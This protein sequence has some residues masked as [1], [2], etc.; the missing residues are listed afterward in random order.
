MNR[1]R[2]AGFT[3]I[4]MLVIAPVVIL[5]IG[6]FLT[7]TI[8]MTGEVISSRASNVLAYDVQEALNRIEQDV[9][10][11]TTFLAESN[12]TLVTSGDAQYQNGAA[13]GYNNDSTKWENIRTDGKKALI[14]NMIVTNGNP[15]DDGSGIV[16]L[17][18]QPNACDNPNVTKNKPMTMNVVYF[19]KDDALWR[20]TIMPSN[21]AV[22][23]DTCTTPWQ[24]PSCAPGYT[25]AFCK[26][27][28][29]KLLTGISE[30][31]FSIEYYATGAA[32][33]PNLTATTSS[34]V[35]T[36]K[37]ALSGMQT[38]SVA[39]SA[40]Q[41][42]A[43]R[44]V[45]RSGSLRTTRLDVNATTI[46]ATTTYATPSKPVV[47]ARVTPPDVAVFTWPDSSGGNVKYNVGYRINGGS[48]TSVATNTT[49]RSYSRVAVR[50][51]TV[52]VRVQA[53]NS[54]GTTSYAT[55]S[56]TIPLWTPLQLQNLWTNYSTTYGSASYTK[57]NDGMVVIKGMIK[58]QG[59]SSSGEV[60][61]VLPEGYR[62]AYLMN[63][64]Q[65]GSGATYGSNVT[66]NPA[67]EIKVGSGMSDTWTALNNIRFLPATSQY[68]WTNFSPFLAGWSNRNNTDDPPF[69][70]AIDG[71]GRV[72]I[73]AA[74]SSGTTTS[75]TAFINLPVETRPST[76]YIFSFRSGCNGFNTLT[77]TTTALQTRSLC[78]GT[79]YA[80]NI[81][82]FP[83]SFTNW[84]THTSGSGGSL[85]NGWAN[86][87]SS[88]GSA[89]YTKTSDD[90]VTLAGL[91]K[92]GT[93]SNGTTLFTLPEGYRPL[94]R[95]VFLVA[96][97]D[98]AARIDVQPNGVV[99][100]QGN[101]SSSWVSF[102]G[103]SFIADQ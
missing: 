80:P 50:G 73:R 65:Y 69:S 91:I 54:A 83:A 74:L 55:A 66:V 45:E 35:A 77:M 100:I 20:R 37:T 86:Y 15:L 16:Y 68:Q 60:I 93:T 67:G 1:L 11:S 102:S 53:T 38:V 10:L 46:A 88:Y 23:A 43:G 82:Y 89:T 22:S 21:Y 58:R 9:K 92:G 95:Q 19:V 75:G 56:T 48:W 81:Q 6:A 70:Y 40:S 17:K 94:E 64:L 101:G 2:S 59:S 14:L 41:A 28:D 13:Q 51:Q 85:K 97:A 96:S 84:T 78:I 57:T 4:E 30:N 7:V 99:T 90:V 63:F 62:P 72:S 24:V 8:S 29:E 26:T 52:E 42:V 36:R 3:L 5:A 39:L 12:V 25:A 31:G 71:I 34:D 32:T 98:E 44:T 61:A 76:Q 49:S 79:N 33:A 47:S 18:N 103:I 27:E 87:G